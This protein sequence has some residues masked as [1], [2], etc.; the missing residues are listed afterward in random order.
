MSGIIRGIDVSSYSGRI[1]LSQAKALKEQWGIQA[2]VIQL[3]GGGPGGTGPN[4]W[5]LSQAYAL[6]SAGLEI[7]VYIWPPRA[8]AEY[9]EDIKAMVRGLIAVTG[10]RPFMVAL[11]VEAGEKVSLAHIQLASRLGPAFIYTSPGEWKKI[12]GSTSFP[13]VPLWEANYTRKF[14]TLTGAWTGKWPTEEDHPWDPVTP[15]FKES[16]AWQFMGTT[17]L[18]GVSC[19]LNVFHP[20]LFS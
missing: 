17:S 5:M 11:D 6:S 15:G 14:R 7:G 9:F 2:A 20:K 1:T 13:D 8:I 16:P 19:D 12:M 3:W 10:K 18:S 4:R